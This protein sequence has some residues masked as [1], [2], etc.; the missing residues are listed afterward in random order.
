MRPAPFFLRPIV[1]C[2]AAFALIAIAPAETVAQEK[3]AWSLTGSVGLAAPLGAW[4]S[5]LSAG[6]EYRLSLSRRRATSP[7]IFEA[8]VATHPFDFSASGLASRNDG[9][10]RGYIRQTSLGLG[11]RRLVLERPAVSSW[12]SGGLSLH[13]VRT[14]A[15]RDTPLPDPTLLRDEFV[16]GFHMGA[17]IAFAR[18]RVQPVFDVRLQYVPLSDRPLLS[19]P[20][21]IGLRF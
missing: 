12:I 19:V 20:L 4:R 6:R 21:T 7:W 1:V 15:W 14:S 5:D 13:S 11:V 8:E 18:W 17:G 2:P 9:S 16:P 3:P 10:A